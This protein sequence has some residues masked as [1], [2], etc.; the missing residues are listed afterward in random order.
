MTQMQQLE[1][2][3]LVCRMEKRDIL[4]IH[5]A[6]KQL[7]KQGVICLEYVKFERN[8]A[9]PMTKGLTRKIV[10]EMLRGIGMKPIY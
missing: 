7:L 5:S 9:D 4:I 1:L 2:S 6:V 8:L 10:L 3:K